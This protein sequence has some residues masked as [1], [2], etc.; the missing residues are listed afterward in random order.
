[1]SRM[2]EQH[3]QLDE[4]GRGKC[5]VPMWSNG[6]D[7]GFCNEESY[8]FRPECKTIPG[9]WWD[10]GNETRVDGRYSGYVP[11]L[12]CPCHGGPDTRTFKD[13]NMWCAVYPNF[14]NLQ[15][16]AS[17]FGETPETARLDL[18]KAR[19]K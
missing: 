10:R 19:G 5:S 6:G 3:K 17:G 8:G 13:G 12:A 18:K 4:N 11:G 7:A 1:M 15:E 14:I 9:P 16:S 2:G